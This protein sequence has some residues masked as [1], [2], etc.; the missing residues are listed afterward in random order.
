M[1]TSALL[2]L[3]L[4]VLGCSAER[5]KASHLAR[6]DHYIAAED[7]PSALIELKNALQ[8]DPKN[9]ETNFRIGDLYRQM[10][11]GD[12]ASFYFSEAIR[13]DPGH[14]GA[15]LGQAAVLFGQDRKG[16]RELIE[17]VLARDPANALAH[18]RASEL[19]LL[20]SDTATAL[21]Q[22]STATQLA[23]NDPVAWIGV[24][25]VRRAEIRERELRHEAP[26]DALFQA[27]I[28][29]YDR[30]IALLKDGNSRLLDQAWLA[31][32]GVLVSWPGHM[33]EAAQSYRD[34]AAALLA[35]PIK[36]ERKVYLLWSAVTD[37]ADRND[38]EL[39]R[40]ALGRVLEIKPDSYAAWQALADLDAQQGKTGSAT[41]ARLIEQRPDD[42][43]AHV[44]YARRLV[45][46]DRFTDAVS[47]LE[48]MSAGL[49]EPKAVLQ[50]LA[51]IQISAG[52]IEDARPVVDRVSR[53]YPGDL[54]TLILSA[55]LAIAEGRLDDA[56]TTLRLAGG[57]DG[58]NASV[59]RLLAD[60]EMK[61]GKPADAA[62]ALRK[63]I[64]SQDVPAPIPWLRELGR[65][66]AAAGDWV[67]A[68]NTYRLILN[69]T[70]SLMPEDFPRLA[71]ALYALGEPEPARKQLEI[72]LD[73]PSPPLSAILLYAA[74]E[75]KRDPKRTRALL[76]SAVSRFPESNVA[77][78]RLVLLDIAE[79]DPGAAIQRIDQQLASKPEAAALW[80]MRA[81]T[82][83]S[84]GKA[85]EA[86]SDA[87]RAIDLDPALPGAMDLY[88]SLLIT[89]GHAEDA[90]RTLQEQEHSGKLA[91]PARIL[92][93]RLLLERGDDARAMSLL[94]EV[95]Q[96]R[97]DLPGVKNDLAYLLMKTG[98]DLQRA[99]TLAQEARAARPEQ[100][101]FADTLGTILLRL[102]LPDAA[103]A[104]LQSATELAA[105]KTIVRASAEYHLGLALKAAGRNADAAD[106]FRRSLDSQSQFPEAEEARSE[107]RAL[108]DGG[109]SKRPS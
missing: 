97:Q 32:S 66:Q 105:D 3:G 64:D 67:E 13:L 58:R 25:L 17:A 88:A 56:V 107:L 86:V 59:N 38:V 108:S 27:G 47:Y 74:R 92:L 99:L 104:Q 10:G 84:L 79:G 71:Q 30:A 12:N 43:F 29:A 7:Y 73:T 78:W 53:E 20:E 14:E 85:N 87:K 89:E 63:A 94:E 70:G 50:A 36:I 9:A 82:L 100:P 26:D 91:L 8:L 41:L 102:E 69:R 101:E 16:A 52:K 77:L 103:I 42:A 2:V 106:A 80:F 31:R 35:R 96:Q 39:Q 24:G 5:R 76:D 28:E 11:S 37:G 18:I 48:K 61:R 93:A 60:V 15:M 40:W 49:K 34:A 44:L 45:K 62:A 65:M 75:G 68:A 19:A 55:R 72:I 51:E 95:L 83:A 54:E 22:A 1:A 21:Q 6:A 33:V 81:R 4:V 46:E 57:P 109:D 23:P 90:V 98:G